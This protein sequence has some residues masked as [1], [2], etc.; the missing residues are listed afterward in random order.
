MILSKVLL[1][2]AV[3]IAR[4]YNQNVSNAIFEQFT[5]T[6][7]PVSTWMLAPTLT[8]PTPAD[9]TIV[10]QTTRGNLTELNGEFL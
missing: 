7:T 1:G 6:L 8:P 4:T 3:P 10:Q 5:I 2:I 9:L